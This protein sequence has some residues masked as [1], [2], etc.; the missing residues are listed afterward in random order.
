MLDFMFLFF[1]LYSN[2]KKLN[3][4]FDFEIADISTSLENKKVDD[5]NEKMIDYG[6]PIDMIKKYL[7]MI[8]N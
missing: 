4:N 5:K 1:K 6:F 2:K 3:Y 8:V 7:K